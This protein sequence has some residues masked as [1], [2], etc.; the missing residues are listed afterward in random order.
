MPYD[1]YTTLS[2]YTVLSAFVRNMGLYVFAANIPSVS[3]GS[4]SEF[5]Y[6]TGI[7]SVQ[8]YTDDTMMAPPSVMSHRVHSPPPPCSP[9]QDDIMRSP[10]PV[11]SQISSTAAMDTDDKR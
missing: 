1:K 7:P 11:M 3:S 6:S 10:P 4:G 9:Q 2:I 8:S 5:N